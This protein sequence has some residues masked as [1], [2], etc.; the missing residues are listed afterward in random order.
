MNLQISSL[1][2]IGQVAPVVAV[3]N[4]AADTKVGRF[5]RWRA[6]NEA[7]AGDKIIPLASP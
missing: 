2:N 4:A 6:G 3:L 5:T 7:A 1:V